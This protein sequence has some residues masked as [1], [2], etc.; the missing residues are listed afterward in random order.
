MIRRIRLDG[1]AMLI[2]LGVGL[3]SGLGPYS[4]AAGNPFT[5]RHSETP[6]AAPQV[7][8]AHVAVV[9]RALLTFQREANRMI[10]QHMRAIATA[11]PPL[12][13]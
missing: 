8:R 2:L 3:Y 6:A 12:R 10:A 7:E 5:G 11:R 9:G 4:P 13:C 1:F